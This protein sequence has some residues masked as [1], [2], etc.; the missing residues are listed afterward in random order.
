MFVWGMVMQ[1]VLLSGRGAIVVPLDEG[2][3][4]SHKAHCDGA[5]TSAAHKRYVGQHKRSVVHRQTSR[6]CACGSQAVRFKYNAQGKS[7]RK[8]VHRE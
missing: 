2:A 7:Q 3:G 6:T 8:S 1:G 4:Q 5:C